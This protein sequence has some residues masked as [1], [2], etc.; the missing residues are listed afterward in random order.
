MRTAN[1][2]ASARTEEMLSEARAEVSAMKAKAQREIENDRRKAAG[3]L[4]NDI[5]ALALDLAGRVVEKEIDAKT[6]GELIRDFIDRVGDV[7]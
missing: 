1:E 5:S 2:R 7:S 6:H 4:K 3:E